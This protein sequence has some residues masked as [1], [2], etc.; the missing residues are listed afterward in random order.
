[1]NRRQFL[2]T[3]STAC[4]AAALPVT[5]VPAINWAPKFRRVTQR[6]DYGHMTGICVVM[7]DAYGRKWR[8]A[9]RM[10]TEAWDKYSD[11]DREH[12]WKILEGEVSRM[13]ARAAK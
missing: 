4:L 9:G 10:Y 11:A 13:A 6:Y 12:F 2:K 3:V 7:I 5:A 1:M 8:S